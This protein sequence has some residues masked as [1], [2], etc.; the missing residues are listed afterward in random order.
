MTDFLQTYF[1]LIFV[2]A[3]ALLA[4]VT[5][6]LTSWDKGPLK[7]RYSYNPEAIQKALMADETL[8]DEERAWMK[9]VEALELPRRHLVC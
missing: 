8:T 4:S 6:W 3:V 9:E 5:A 2:G 7:A 1:F